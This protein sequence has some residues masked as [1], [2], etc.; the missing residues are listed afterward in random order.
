[1][2]K[3]NKPNPNIDNPIRQ[4]DSINAVDSSM[5]THKEGDDTIQSPE[6]TVQDS[7]MG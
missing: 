5:G 6:K 1:M 4:E 7:K 3:K 2:I